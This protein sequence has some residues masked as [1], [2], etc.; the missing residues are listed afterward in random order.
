M[1]NIKSAKKRIRVIQKKTLINKMRISQ[2]RTAVK[3]F[4]MALSS[5]DMALA[6]E[7][8]RFVQKKLTQIAAKGTIHKNTA[9]RKI[10]RLTKKL[11]KAK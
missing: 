10:S 8:L 11:N 5:G 4:E 2:A 9:A 7:K 3:R 1:A 6:S